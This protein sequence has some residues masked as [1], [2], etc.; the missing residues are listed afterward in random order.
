MATFNIINR[1]WYS[2][3]EKSQFCGMPQRGKP[4]VL[5]HAQL[6]CALEVCEFVQ[7]III[8]TR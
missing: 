8:V 4:T 7:Y 1:N 3:T 2:Y 6:G 5:R